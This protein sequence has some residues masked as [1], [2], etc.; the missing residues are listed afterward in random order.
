MRKYA[1]SLT[2]P[3]L[4]EHLAI[5]D[6]R[7]ETQIIARG[8]MSYKTVIAQHCVGDELQFRINGVRPRDSFEFII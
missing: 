1:A 8:K 7:R 2:L 3:Q 6:Y 5:V 4:W